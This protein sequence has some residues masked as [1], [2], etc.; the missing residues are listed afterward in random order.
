MEINDTNYQRHINIMSIFRNNLLNWTKFDLWRIY[1]N[2]VWKTILTW[3][4]IAIRFLF[5][6]W[7][8]FF[9]HIFVLYSYKYL[10]SFLHRLDIFECIRKFNVSVKWV[11]SVKRSQLHNWPSL[12]AKP[13][14]FCRLIVSFFEIFIVYRL[15][16]SMRITHLA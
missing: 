1:M 9:C 4:Q 16:Y 3:F 12:W 5:I 15:S 7:T 10:N 8:F 6:I 13:P 14:R 11:R 2:P